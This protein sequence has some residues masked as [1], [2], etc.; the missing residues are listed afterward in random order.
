MEKSVSYSLILV[1]ITI[2]FSIIPIGF[3]LFFDNILFILLLGIVFVIILFE[4]LKY[5]LKNIQGEG[6]GK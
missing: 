3:A 1:I 2:I 6:N 5:A 4:F